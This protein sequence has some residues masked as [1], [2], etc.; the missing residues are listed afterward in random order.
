MGTE[1]PKALPTKYAITVNTRELGMNIY[2]RK[3]YLQ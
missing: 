2:V 1:F 3:V